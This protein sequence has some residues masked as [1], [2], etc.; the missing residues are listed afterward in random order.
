MRILSFSTLY[1]NAAQPIHGVFVENRLRH[2]AAS[3]R[4]E[5]RV[6]APVPWFPPIGR[7]AGRYGVYTRAPRTEVRHGLEVEH[8]RYPTIPRIGMAMAPL[9]LA[10]SQRPTIARIIREGYDFDILDAHYFYPD[11]VAGAL[12]GRWFG[13]PVVITARG[14]DLSLIPQ[15]PL[16]RRQIQWAAAEAA[17]M[18]TVCQALKEA[19]VD[20]DVAGE[21]VTVLRN[22]V[23][24]ETFKPLADAARAAARTRFGMNG[25]ALASVGGLIERKGHHLV[26]AALRTMPDVILFIAGDGPERPALMDLAQ[27]S[28]V[29]DRVRFLGVVPHKELAIL[30][31]AADALVLA[32]SREGWANVLL[33]AMACGTP[34][35]ASRIWGTPEVVTV[36]AAG[37]LMA[38][39]SAAGVVAGVARLRSAIPNRAATRAYAENFSWHA[40]TQ[41]QLDLFESILAARRNSP[42]GPPIRR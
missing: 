21:R 28:G 10:V 41:G 38:E 24:L 23:D 6:V 37:V 11:G 19:L 29:A 27:S 18:I 5:V 33:E 12:L 40:T 39:R 32:S 26:I 1:P 8:P 9:L 2:L 16:P 4:V 20:L 22:G 7:L 3:G 30:Y 34:V 25:F 14:T 15:Y 13:K 42:D 17:H 36:P 35:V 31:G